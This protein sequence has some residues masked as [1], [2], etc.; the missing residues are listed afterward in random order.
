MRSGG[1]PGGEEEG[2]IHCRV[3]NVGEL[4]KKHYCL[5]VCSTQTAEEMSVYRQGTVAVL[6]E[7]D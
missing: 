4:S 5:R 6:L 7:R 1:D 2:H 3:C